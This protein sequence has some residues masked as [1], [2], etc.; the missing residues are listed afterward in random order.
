MCVARYTRLDTG[1]ANQITHGV[2]PHR[3]RVNRVVDYPGAV[4]WGM[5]DVWFRASQTVDV[6]AVG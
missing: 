5:C 3:P 1:V 6:D 4:A 2:G